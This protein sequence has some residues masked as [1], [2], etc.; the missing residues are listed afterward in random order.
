MK[1]VYKFGPRAGEVAHVPR[2]QE[3]QVL[4]TAGIIEEIPITDAERIPH[5]D[6]TPAPFYAVAE[7]GV[8]ETTYDGPLVV[9]K[10]GY[11]TRR[12]SK[13]P[14]DCP[15]AVVRRWAVLA[16]VNPEVEAARF[17]QEK[18]RVEAASRKSKEGRLW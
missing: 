16:K 5:K 13:P 2:S 4:L 3:I 1:I 15:E 10:I 8:M 12:Y 14:V 11:E 9:Q 17:E 6:D 18:A 7:W